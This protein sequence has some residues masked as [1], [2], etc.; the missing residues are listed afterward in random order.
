MALATAV[1]SGESLAALDLNIN[2]KLA[3]LPTTASRELIVPS[4]LRS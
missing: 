2:L 4:K 1:T 3:D